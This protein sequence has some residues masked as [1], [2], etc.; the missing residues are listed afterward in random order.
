M[1]E[2]LAVALRFL[3]VV[4]IFSITASPIRGQEVRTQ[5]A[6]A[7][8]HIITQPGKNF[9]IYLEITN[10]GDPQI[11]SLKVFPLGKPDLYGNFSL[12][13][14]VTS[15]ISIG[16]P[17][18]RYSD[19]APFLMTSRE[20]RSVP[21]QINVP[22]T[23]IPGEYAY[24]IALISRP[25]P[26]RQGALTTQI[27]A[28]AGTLFLLT[29]T[30]DNRDEKK[31]KT[32]V[33]HPVSNNKLNLPG[34]RIQI[35]KPNSPLPLRLVVRN[36]GDF[37][38]T[39]RSEITLSHTGGKHKAVKLLPAFIF[40]NSD[41]ILYSAEMSEDSC[42]KKY[43]PELCNPDISYI[44][45]GLPLGMHTLSVRVSFGESAP[46]LYD[47]VTVA[48]IPIELTV[49]S[50]AAGLLALAGAVIYIARKRINSNN[51]HVKAQNRK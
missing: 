12:L 20:K 19:E 7:L 35:I 42:V 47:T 34:T 17:D 27:A 11:F 44:H 1:K 5:V 25:G 41:R 40:P 30:P 46:I 33:F 21:V 23:T 36:D 37:G 8:Q 9:N 49:G 22:Q 24:S 28:G 2:Q 39:A 14:N 43:R 13:E 48:V 51:T 38:I 16:F 50:M 32:V 15:E 26:A 4:T 29:V 45:P 18:I 3:I 10:I 31:A 6:P